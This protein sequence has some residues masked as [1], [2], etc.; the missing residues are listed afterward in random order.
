MG[1]VSE[2]FPDISF[3]DD[4]TIDEVMAQM[5]EDYQERYSEIT[6]K[7]IA[8]SQADPYRLIMYAC[9]LQ[10]YQAMQY[11][12]YAAKMGLL[13]Y[14]SD[15]YLDNLAAL[16]G[17]QRIEA[18]AA[19]TTLRFSIEEALESAVAIPEGTRVT[20]GNDV[21]FATDEYAEIPAGE[22]S[23]TVSATCTEAGSVGNGF[24]AGEFNELVEM[25][26][27]ITESVNIETTDGGAD[28][29]DDDSLKDRIFNA[30]SS[31]SVAGSASAYEY[32]T[33]SVDPT[34]SDVIVTSSSAGVVDIYFV[35]ND[36]E[37]PEESLIQKVSDYLNDENI[38]PLTDAVT[39][40]APETQ[41]YDVEFTYYIASSDKSITS[42]IQ[43]D[44]ET[45]VS[46]YNAW[47]TEKIGRDINPSYLIQK[48]MDAGVKRIE[49]ASPVFTDLDATSIAVLGTV[50]MTYGG[51][52]DD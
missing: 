25:L 47:Q 50:T 44:V 6:G 28:E 11:A 41:T 23:V 16:R 49:V 12:D 8:L 1:V 38:R 46:I 21:Y 2:N 43:A 34:I 13:K 17:V 29:E 14:S 37:L 10:I 31:Y 4:C 20:N 48:V 35:C 18:T 7:D 3:I 22:L 24:E 36:G 40:Q 52:E 45:A 15:A 33:K 9:A 42:T 5:I 19:V 51:L 27:Y 32:H 30:P 26:A 39:V